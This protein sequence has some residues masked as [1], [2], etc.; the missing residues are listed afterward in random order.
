[1]LWILLHSIIFCLETTRVPDISLKVLKPATEFRVD[2]ANT[3]DHRFLF[4]FFSFF[5]RLWLT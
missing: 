2:R 3:Q 4:F 5:L 1:M